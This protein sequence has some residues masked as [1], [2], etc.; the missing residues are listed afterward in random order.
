MN[1]LN[2]AK[3]IAVISAL[4]E[5]C[6][7]RSTVRMTGV[8]KNTIVKLLAAVGTACAQ[9]LHEHLRDVSCRYV[10]CDEIWS[11]C[12]AKAKNLA[13]AKAAPRGAGDVWTWVALDADSKLLISYLVG[14]RDGM[15]ASHF[16]ADVASR[17]K[18][19][20]QLTTDGH[21]AYLQAVEDG[22]GGSIDYAMLIKLYGSEGSKDNPETRY[23]PGECIGTRKEVISGDPDLEHVSTS[24]SERQNLTMRMR[25]RRFIRLTNAFSKKIANHEHAIAL[26]AMHYNFVRRHQSLRV[27]PAMA[28]GLT[29][30]LWSLEDIV[31]LLDQPC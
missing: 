8:A 20:V 28:A 16:I 9:Y 10:Q 3:R 26:Y 24:F 15:H 13:T 19:R 2:A 22:F 1:K 21:A 17:L 11:F 14:A 18:H 30:R 5:G 27:T 6:S 23:S 4:V 7:I 12:Y 29:N 25:L 31:G